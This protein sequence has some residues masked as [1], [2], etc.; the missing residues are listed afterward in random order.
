MKEILLLA[1][2]GGQGVQT[3]GKALAY[4]GGLQGFCVTMDTQY[5]GNMRGSPSNCTV[6][7]SDHPIGSP[8]E[9]CADRLIVFSQVA[10][11]KLV[12]RV[13]PGGT[14][15]Y[16]STLA[17]LS[18][19]LRSDLS[20]LPCPVTELA[21]KIGDQRCANGVM[22]GFLSTQLKYLEREKLREGLLYALGTKPALHEINLRAFDAGSRFSAVQ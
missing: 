4:A 18:P 20:F 15:Y 10:L 22:A 19:E 13:M 11:D 14:V 6:I 12:E 7:I 17:A 2:Y 1:G 3:L 9:H 21:E 8:R 16:N 5:S